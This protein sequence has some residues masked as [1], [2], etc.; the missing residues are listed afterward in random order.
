MARG[1]VT[2]TSVFLETQPVA[3]LSRCTC[4]TRVQGISDEAAAHLE[5]AA[6]EQAEL[7]AQ[8][9][10][11]AATE[12]A[13]RRHCAAARA[14]AEAACAERARLHAMLQVRVMQELACVLRR[15]AAI[16]VL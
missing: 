15:T 6:A 10:A 3:P 4:S 2:G 1:A 8:L 16:L 13:L 5:E 7:C 9:Q 12:A 14:E 11:A